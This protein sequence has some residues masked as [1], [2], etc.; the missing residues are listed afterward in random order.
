MERYV[1]AIVVYY[2]IKKTQKGRHNIW[3]GRG[4]PA[5]YSWPSLPPFW[6]SISG[7]KDQE[8]NP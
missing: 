4:S 7:L 6:A 3:S 8:S 2:T 5:V 1:K